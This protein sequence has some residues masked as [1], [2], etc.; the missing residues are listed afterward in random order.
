MRRSETSIG[1]NSRLTTEGR[2]GGFGG[3][4][5][6]GGRA[7]IDCRGSTAKPGRP[8]LVESGGGSSQA[9]AR[10][11]FTLDIQR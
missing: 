6:S 7:R 1:R 5:F 10:S 4:I 9:S 3:R 2:G 11:Q 8:Q